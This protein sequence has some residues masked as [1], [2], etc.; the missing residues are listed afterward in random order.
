MLNYISTNQDRPTAAP[1]DQR[2]KFESAKQG[3]VGALRPLKEFLQADPQAQLLD[4]ALGAC[5][6]VN[7]AA[8][9]RNEELRQEIASLQEIVRRLLAHHLGEIF[10]DQ[11]SNLGLTNSQVDAVIQ[12][13]SRY[14]GET[15]EKQV[16]WVAPK[17][18]RGLVDTYLAALSKN[19]SAGG[20]NTI[21]RAFTALTVCL[22]E[23]PN[24][25]DTTVSISPSIM[26]YHLLTNPAIS[27]DDLISICTPSRW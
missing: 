24:H 19:D 16:P 26:I 25:G 7:Q 21:K 6:E 17:S 11:M 2:A 8:A 1:P 20:I 14:L 13:T 4:S 23:C 12:K 15:L 10:K 9:A 5:H 3:L 22:T 27:A 18:P